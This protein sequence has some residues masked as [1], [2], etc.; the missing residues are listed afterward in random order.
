MFSDKLQPTCGQHGQRRSLH[1]RLSDES[2][3]STPLVDETLADF[4]KQCL[5]DGGRS[6]QEAAFEIGFSDVHSSIARS[7]RA[8]NPSQVSLVSHRVF[9]SVFF[10]VARPW[11]C[12]API[13][14]A[15][16]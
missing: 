6:I 4:A 11:S 15:A 14:D 1:R 2:V 5:E 8:R 16:A 10:I 9:S 7:S 12:M 3:S 13:A